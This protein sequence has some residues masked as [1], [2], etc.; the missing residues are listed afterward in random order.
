MGAEPGTGQSLGR[1]LKRLCLSPILPVIIHML[2][3]IAALM[4]SPQIQSAIIALGEK[5]AGRELVHSVWIARL[6]GWGHSLMTYSLCALASYILVFIYARARRIKSFVF[7]LFDWK[8]P[9]AAIIIWILLCLCALPYQRTRHLTVYIPA[10]ILAAAVYLIL[11]KLKS[12]SLPLMAVTAVLFSLVLSMAFIDRGQTWGDDFAEYITQAKVLATGQDRDDRP[13][14]G[15]KYGTAILILPFYKLAGLNLL[16]LKIPMILCFIS[17]IVLIIPFYRKRLESQRTALAALTLA[18]CPAF[19]CYVNNILSD[20]PFL[21]FSTLTI[22]CIYGIYTDRGSTT[23]RYISAISAGFFTMYAFSCRF[24]GL[25]L[26]LAL[27]CTEILLLLKAA[28]PKS[29]LLNSWTASLNGQGRKTIPVHL[30]YYA[31]FASCYILYQFL[32]PKAPARSDLGFL[33]SFSPKGL[34]TNLLAYPFL[35]SDFFSCNGLVPHP[36]CQAAYMVFIPL[37]IIGLAR[38]AKAEAPCTIYCLGLIALYIIWPGP[39]DFR[40]LFPILPF[41]LM[42][43]CYGFDSLKDVRLRK[44]YTFSA[45]LAVCVF[46]CSM[47]YA[48]TEN[49]RG[50]RSGDYQ[51]FSAQAQEAYEYIREGTG[52]DD[53][54]LFFKP[55]VLYLATGR[56][57]AEYKKDEEGFLEQLGEYDW[58]LSFDGQYPDIPSELVTEGEIKRLPQGIVLEKAFCNYSFTLYRI[59]RKPGL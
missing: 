30:A 14:I 1:P 22:T 36:L 29:R 34:M 6:S 7:D 40:F 56:P 9:F 47:L 41:M 15:Y 16:V 44:C 3:A 12:P 45:I 37:V 39:R 27:T 46:I 55:R 28:L 49:I 13:Q 5:L 43:A 50:K 58:L 20:I 32:L 24:Q 52:N 25:L 17:F 21:L 54:I 51:A 59:G 53:R 48:G 35:F 26:L 31:S 10:L 2:P 42:F 38:K 23:R 19:L 33:R 4:L 18:V 8:L 57:S 11:P